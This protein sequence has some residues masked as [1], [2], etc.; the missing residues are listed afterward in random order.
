MNAPLIWLHEESL[1]V[2]HPVFNAAPAGTKAIFIWDGD[3]LAQANYSLKRLVFIYETVC[4]LP[5]D[6]V[7]GNT[8]EVVREFSPSV[9]YIPVTNNPLILSII[10]TLKSA[11]PIQLVE[12]EPFVVMKKSTDF[13][14]FFQYWN[15]AEKTAFQKNGGG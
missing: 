15:K 4:E 7:E 3:A 5:I 2:T 10:D 14:R 1:R 9:L 12:D 6:I 13:R 11:M 8:L